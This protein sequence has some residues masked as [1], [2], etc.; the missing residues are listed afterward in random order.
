MLI[1]C[2]TIYLIVQ[3]MIMYGINPERFSDTMLNKIPLG[4]YFC[5]SYWKVLINGQIN[6]SF[7]ESSSNDLPQAELLYFTSNHCKR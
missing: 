3:S 2:I 1:L 6:Q 4:C 5:I 7:F